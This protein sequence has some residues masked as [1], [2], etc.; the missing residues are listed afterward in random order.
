M[1]SDFRC[2]SLNLE[3]KSISSHVSDLQMNYKECFFYDFK[4]CSSSRTIDSAIFVILTT[5]NCI[6]LFRILIQQITDNCKS[7]ASNG[8]DIVTQV[9]NILLFSISYC[10]TSLFKK[11]IFIS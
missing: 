7:I 3:L 1:L 2:N 4:R 6:Q 5:S 11:F 8:V 9:T 10:I